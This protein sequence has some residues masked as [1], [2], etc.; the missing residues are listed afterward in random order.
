MEP[1]FTYKIDN[2]ELIDKLK[3]D[4]Y[5]NPEHIKENKG[6]QNYHRILGTIE[7]NDVWNL[8]QWFPRYWDDNREMYDYLNKI[9]YPHDPEYFIDKTWIK[10]Y[11]KGY[12]ASLHR[13]F[14]DGMNL[15]N[16]YTNVILLD[17]SDDI[18]GGV[19]VIAGDSF[20]INWEDPKA[21]YNLRERLYTR[22]L[23]EPG[24]A[25]VW[26]EKAVHGVSMIENGH[27]LVLVCTKMKRETE[28]QNG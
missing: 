21:R 28:R 6:K 11:P 3:K 25:V 15:E 27:R 23:K 12:F 16:Q 19:I 17:Q 5:D 8:V 20:E 1:G 9:T 10:Y 7:E 18:V 14:G 24:D 2:Q 26:D 4:F 13:E 22:F